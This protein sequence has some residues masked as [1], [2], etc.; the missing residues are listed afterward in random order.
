MPLYS[1]INPN[2]MIRLSIQIT[3]ILMFLGCFTTNSQESKITSN[4]Y[5]LKAN[6][7]QTQ[8]IACNKDST[9]AL[10]GYALSG[11]EPYTYQWSENVT[12]FTDSIAFN[13]PAGNYTLTVTDSHDSVATT[14]FEILEPTPISVDLDATDLGCHLSANGAITTL[15][16]GGTGEYTYAWTGTLGYNPTTKNQS[17]LSAG[18]FYVLVSD[19]NN[20]TMA[21]SI[22]VLQPTALSSTAVVMPEDPYMSNGKIELILSGGTQ[23]Y[24]HSWEY[25]STPIAGGSNKITD[26]QE[27]L[28]RAV[29]KDDNLCEYDTSIVVSGQ[30][31]R[32][33]LQ[34]THI[35][36][37]GA[38]N[39]ELRASIASGYDETDTYSY[40]FQNSSR[41][42]LQTGRSST[43]KNLP[44]GE[45]FVVLQEDNTSETALASVY[46]NQ[47]DS[48]RVSFTT[49]DANCYQEYTSV[50][51]MISGGTP[52]YSIA[53]SNGATSESLAL[54]YASKYMITITDA[55]S[56]QHIDSIETFGPDSLAVSIKETKSIVCSDS[57]TGQLDADVVGGTSPYAYQWNDDSLQTTAYAEN[58]GAGVYDLIVT[59]NHNCKH[60]A[61]Y[62]LNSPPLLELM[63]IDTG[64]IS[65]YGIPDGHFGV[66]MQGGTQPYSY[67]WSN[68]A[69]ED[70]NVAINL[71]PETY[72]VRVSDAN[73]CGDSIY[74]F[75]VKSPMASLTITEDKSAHGDNLC[76]NDSLGSL[77]AEASGGWGNYEYSLNLLDWATSPVFLTL[78]AQDYTVSVRDRKGC[79][80]NTEISISEPQKLSVSTTDVGSTVTAIGS[81]GTLPYDYS[82]DKMEWQSLGVFSDLND[83]AYRVYLTDA[84]NCDI[85][86]SDVIYIQS[87]HNNINNP[88]TAFTHIYPNPSNGIF[89]ISFEPMSDGEHII[90]VYSLSGIPVYREVKMLHFKDDH[91]IVVDL[92]NQEK[93]LY[94][95]KINGLFLKRKLVIE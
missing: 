31:L 50:N 88:E 11:T 29:I 26:L 35:T 40:E 39:G 86:S 10:L 65:C 47:P 57:V 81:G 2:S 7:I 24:T 49:N 52:E 30:S 1:V 15:V 28:Y 8:K 82:I 54:V 23:P 74:T 32:V 58:L 46:I 62:K 76:F 44:A 38:N 12:H 91:T 64:H 27:G 56:C 43:L 19:E 61:S 90:E 33:V 93:G 5:P 83:G 41:V 20:C 36:C 51:A 77:K 18:T 34:S 59:D 42:V 17:G 55:N 25:E 21:D 85:D 66:F 72:T 6:L 68:S 94:L 16:S 3:L 73:K 89:R 4:N 9:A 75:K 48:L 53:W 69:I 95:L 67:E 70:T 14:N 92:T 45:Y 71:Y 37:A 22:D 87:Q 80:D 63:R 78:V 79:M 60:T 13:L 84:N